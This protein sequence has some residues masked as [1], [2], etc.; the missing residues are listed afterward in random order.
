[1]TDFYLN[2]DLIE[3][4][5]DRLTTLRIV[6]ARQLA[7]AGV[8]VLRLGDDV[9]GQTGMLMSLDTWRR[10]L[11]PRLARVIQAARAVKPNIHIFYH[12]DG[13]CWPVIPELI[14]IGVTVLNPIQPECMDPAQLKAEFGDQLAFWGTIGTQTTMPF[15]TPEDVRAAVK[16]RIET[17][18][19]SGGLLIAP[20]HVLEP[21]V[22]WQNVVAFIEAVE[23]YGA[24]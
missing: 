23:E 20:T 24:Y 22:P 7:Q 3:A 2:P 19:R 13:D 17:V 11:K 15:G 9:A 5:L 21:E 1:M 12:S 18:G 8:D 6:E 10:W 4:L 14:E 16:E